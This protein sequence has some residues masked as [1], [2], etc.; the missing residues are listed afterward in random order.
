MLANGAVFARH[1]YAMFCR[2]IDMADVSFAFDRRHDPFGRDDPKSSWGR[3][4]DRSSL[5]WSDVPNASFALPDVGP[6]WLPIDNDF[7]QV[8]EVPELCESGSTKT[9]IG[10]CSRTGAV[11]IRCDGRRTNRLTQLMMIAMYP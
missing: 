9:Y 11:R 3:D 7:D 2:E 1:A 5:Q 10:R 4:P 6:P 8:K